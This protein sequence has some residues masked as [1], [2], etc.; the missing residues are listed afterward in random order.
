MFSPRPLL[1]YIFLVFYLYF[2]V[3][4]YSQNGHLS[5]SVK[6]LADYAHFMPYFALFGKREN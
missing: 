5:T 6:H 3:L 2:N 1:A 4:F